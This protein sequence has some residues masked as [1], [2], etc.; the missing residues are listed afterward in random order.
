MAR[1]GL[2]AVLV[3]I[4][5]LDDTTKRSLE[6]RAASPSRRLAVVRA[7]ADAGVPVGVLVAPVIPLVTDHELEQILEQAAAAGARSAGYVLLRLPLEIE[8]LFEEW[9][10]AHAP[11]KAEHVMSLMRQM[12]GGRAYD[13]RFG[14]RQRGRGQYARAAGTTLRH[15]EPALRSRCARAPPARHATVP[16]AVPWRSV[17]PCSVEPIYASPDV[18][19]NAGSHDHHP[20]AFGLP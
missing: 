11:L 3:S 4:T 5:T 18:M 8:Y 10:R 1:S 7:L 17:G 15:R 16:P 6:P 19:V 14:V 9:L 20:H 12:H 13:S 2:A